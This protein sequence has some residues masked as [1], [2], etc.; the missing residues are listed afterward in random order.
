MK[1]KLLQLCD[2]ISDKNVCENLVNRFSCPINAD[3]ENFLK[4]KAAEYERK[5][6][7]RTYFV[8]YDDGGDTHILV[9][10]FSLALITI[11]VSSNVSRSIIRKI[12]GNEGKKQCVALLLGQLGKNHKDGIHRRKLITGKQL[13]GI[14][15]NIIRDIQYKIGGRT[16]LVECK[17]CSALR[18]FYEECGFKL[19]N[20]SLKEDLLR[21]FIPI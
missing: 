14:A 3:V 16:L 1:Y 15:Q 4:D 10:Y 12:S 21:Y 9:G 2:I 5:N 17:N 8:F 6:L 19:V 11:D 18:D 20:K 13:L 7:S